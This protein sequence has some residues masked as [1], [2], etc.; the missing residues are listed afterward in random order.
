MKSLTSVSEEGGIPP[1]PQHF[2]KQAFIAELSSI[3]DRGAA[4]DGELQAASRI[5]GIMGEMGLS[6]ATEEFR[7]PTRMPIIHFVHFFTIFLASILSN[8]H[9]IAATIIG[10]VVLLSFWGEFTHRFFILRNLIPH[11][12]S[13]NVIGKMGKDDEPYKVVIS[14]HMDAARAGWIFDSRLSNFVGRFK[15]QPLHKTLMILMTVLVVVFVVKAFGGKTWVLSLIF[16]SAAFISLALS[17]LMIQWELSPFAPGANDDLSG[18][19]VMLGAAERLLQSAP[20]GFQF[21][22]VATGAEEAHCSGMKAF[23]KAHMREFD[24][25]WSFFINLEC[26]GGGRLKYVTEEGFIVFQKHDHTLIQIAEIVSRRCGLDFLPTYTVAHSES[27]VPLTKGF[28]SIGLIALS[29]NNVPT[30][31]HQP[32]DVEA[33]INYGLLEDAEAA[34]LEMVRIL[35]EFKGLKYI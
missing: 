34:V 20:E 5:S 18:V 25:K 15:D 12:R 23:M 14:A 32:Q 28:K 7:T 9:P 27:I 10:V 11:R 26:L 35:G 16:N 22:F 13:R 29:E 4:T 19:S 6:V 24:R 31:Y 30:N 8:W 33:N 3:Q 21:V 17:L 1:S 2:S